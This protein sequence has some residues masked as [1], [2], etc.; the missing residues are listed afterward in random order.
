[1]ARVLGEVNVVTKFGDGRRNSG[2]NYS[3]SE[4][5]SGFN[6][7]KTGFLFPTVRE[8]FGYLE[9]GKSG[10]LE[11]SHSPFFV[12]YMF[13]TTRG[14][15]RKERGLLRRNCFTRYFSWNLLFDYSIFVVKFLLEK[16]YVWGRVGLFGPFFFTCRCFLNHPISKI[17][18]FLWL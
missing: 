14:K 8:I 12:L 10:N 2:T 18:V 15:R 9:R 7:A 3:C 17:N 5:Y 11:F 13:H 6:G 4:F 1:M 16:I